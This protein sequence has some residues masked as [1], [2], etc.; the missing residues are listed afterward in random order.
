MKRLLIAALTCLLMP[1][2]AAQTLT[3]GPGGSVVVTCTAGATPAPQPPVVVPTPPPVVTPP[4]SPAAGPIAPAMYYDW[5]RP[6]ANVDVPSRPGT[7]TPLILVV[8]PDRSDVHT[9]EFR[10]GYTS[11]GSDGKMNITLTDPSGLIVDG[12]ILGVNHEH[13]DLRAGPDYGTRVYP[14]NWTVWITPLDFKTPVRANFSH[15]P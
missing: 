13:G 15:A 4:V 11:A 9:L 6:G 1:F 5:S 2:A 3:I 8:P 14:G 7:T 10:L 12:P